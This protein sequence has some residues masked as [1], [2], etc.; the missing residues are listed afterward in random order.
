MSF[1]SA[2]ILDPFLLSLSDLLL[3]AIS[4]AVA[5][6]RVFL[7]LLLDPTWA[8]VAPKSA[9]ETPKGRKSSGIRA[10]L[11][12]TFSSINA[13]CVFILGTIIKNDRQRDPNS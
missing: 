11:S 5:L 2:L 1:I 4:V 3:G 8:H 6:K 7:V 10:P 13:G 12:T 9:P